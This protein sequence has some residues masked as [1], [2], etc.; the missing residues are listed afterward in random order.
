MVVFDSSASRG[1]DSRRR[2]RNALSKLGRVALERDDL[3]AVFDEALD[4]VR[5]VLGVD[6]CGLFT[7]GGSS[8]RYGR[9]VVLRRGDGWDDDHVAEPRGKV[10]RDERIERALTTGSPVVLEDP[11]HDRIDD[12]SLLGAHGIASGATVPIFVG[13]ADGQA[14]GVL[15]AYAS[16]PD[17]VDDEGVAFLARVAELLEPRIENADEETQLEGESDG[18]VETTVER[19]TDAIFALDEEWRF[20]YANDRARTVIDPDGE[21]LLGECV[22]DRFPAA[23]DSTFEREYRDAM[24]TQEPTAFEEY[25]PPLSTWF[26]VNAYPSESGLSV[27]FRDV[28][29]RTEARRELRS[30]NRTLQRLYEITSDA[31]RSF[32]TKLH[33]LLELG[34][35]RLDLDVGYLAAIDEEDDRFEITHCVSE[36]DQLEPG[37][38]IALSET[39]CRQTIDSDGLLAFTNAS[40]DERIDGETYE[41]W[42]ID[43][44]VGG[45]VTVGND[46]FG[47]LCFESEE[48]RQ[49]PFTPTER[50]FVELA[51]QWVGQELERRRREREL[52]ES[53]RRYRTLIENFPNG[54][55]ALVDR[56]LQ[57]VTFGGTLAGSGDV[58]R[59]ELVGTPIERALPRELADIVVPNYENAIEGEPNTIERTV[60]GRVYRFHFA[61]V[62]GVDGDVFAAMG[63]SQEVTE[64]RET[65]RKL[66]E[67]ERHLERVRR[68]TDDLLDAIDDV[69]YVVDEDGELRRWNESLPAVTG[70][71]DDEIDSMAALEFFAEEDRD[72]I[73]DAIAGVFETGHSQVEA[74]L[75]TKD[76]ER[77]PYEFVAS[78]LENPDGDAVL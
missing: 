57:Y 10:V 66:R 11:D 29:D 70:Y 21:G 59:D 19:I 32:E 67:R 41:T 55:V 36:D 49:T 26:E 6:C 40:T 62:R 43:A 46:R 48:P 54:T 1:E 25:V 78:T 30:T 15:G 20:T 31:D 42:G 24:A 18:T 3:E 51:T 61:P 63:M 73:A 2:Q 53:E 12:S 5:A 45:R 23:V 74:E 28:T 75:V 13:S 35:D 52:E 39:Y 58:S 77:I 4:A 9:H 27:F 34:R 33:Q 14:W 64:R 69:F 68:Y 76:G 16:E 7:D 56:D 8:S 65:E 17:A 37:T 44:Y 22:W 50:S 38:E 47:T 60:G 71:T 72:V